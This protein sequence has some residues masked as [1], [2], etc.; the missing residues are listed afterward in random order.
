[1]AEENTIY[2]GGKGKKYS[3]AAMSGARKVPSHY[4]GT[5]NRKYTCLRTKH[6]WLCKIWI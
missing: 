1:M 3:F 2:S 6:Y 4:R 5:Q